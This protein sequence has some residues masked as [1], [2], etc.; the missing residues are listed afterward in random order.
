MSFTVHGV[1]FGSGG[2]TVT[3]SDLDT[4]RSIRGTCYGVRS[5]VFIPYTEYEE[6]HDHISGMLGN[7]V[8]DWVTEL[9]QEGDMPN[10]MVV[11]RASGKLRY[12]GDTK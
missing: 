2:M 10:L 4:Y 5:Q 3:Y 1:E 11:A 8:E 6:A 9:E 7:M 12:G